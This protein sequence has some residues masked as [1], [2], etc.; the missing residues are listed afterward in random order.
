MARTVQGAMSDIPSEGANP[1]DET[2]RAAARAQASWAS[3]DRAEFDTV[4]NDLLPFVLPQVTAIVASKV[5]PEEVEDTAAE[6]LFNFYQRLKETE[7]IASVRA[8][9]RH[10]AGLRCIDVYRARARR[11]TEPLL[12]EQEEELAGS[13]VDPQQM[14]SRIVANDLLES[15]SEEHARILFVRYYLD[16]TVEQTAQILGMT[17]DMVKKRAPEALRQAAR[18][19]EQRKIRESHQ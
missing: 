7:P 10:V 17:V 14:V 16:K 15:L 4:V 8:W 9:L 13:S 6:V 2:D 5:R 18:L 12:D 11:P 3:K 1:P 19:A